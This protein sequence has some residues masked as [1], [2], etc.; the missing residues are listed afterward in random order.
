MLSGYGAAPLLAV[1]GS[2]AVEPARSELMAAGGQW[3][4]LLPGTP[5]LRAAIGLWTRPEVPLEPG[6]DQVIPAQ[7]RGVLTGRQALDRWVVEQTD[8]LL[9]RM[10]VQL[11]AETLLVLASALAVR[12]TWAQPFE[13]WE[14]GVGGR[15]VWWLSR[16]DPDL[17]TVRCHDTANGAMTA[18]TVRGSGAI[19]V[20][21]VV[22]DPAVA[23]NK[24]LAAAVGLG[25]GGA[26][27][28]RLL[29]GLPSPAVSVVETM[30]PQPTVTLSVP[31]FEVDA[32]HDLLACP[33]VFGLVTASDPRR[34]HFPGLSS[35]PLA[36]SQAKQAVMARFSA[37]GFEAA[38]VTAIPAVAGSAPIPGARGLRVD[39][40]RPFAFVAVHRP[41]GTPLVAGWA[42]ES[43]Y[44]VV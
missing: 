22:A 36:V 15:S 37:T 11:T 29:E 8:G 14:R 24:V 40:D 23:R 16:V 19:D 17:S 6:L 43:A 9:E 3:A 44:K 38:A 7:L 10:P 26:D 2:V 12:T 18:V 4:G 31:Y 28:V 35:M 13:A 41:T 34:G 39:L 20:R 42:D 32:E 30:D 1:L 21:L 5:E 33:E 27:A 25:E